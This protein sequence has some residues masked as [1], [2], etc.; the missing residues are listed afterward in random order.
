MER[1]QDPITF[2]LSRPE[3]GIE[4]FRVDGTIDCQYV[5]AEWDGRWVVATEMLVEHAALALA[6]EDALSEVSLTADHPPWTVF[7]RPERLLLALITSCD[8]IDLVEFD[9]F[10]ERRVI[11]SDA[12]RDRDR[13]HERRNVAYMREITR[14]SG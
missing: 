11:G 3:C 6:V 4:T 7:T 12:R 1:N 10:G 5:Q 14:R 13:A 8:E 2:P 9:V